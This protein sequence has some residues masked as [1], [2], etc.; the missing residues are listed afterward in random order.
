[1]FEDSARASGRPITPAEKRNVNTHTNTEKDMERPSAGASM[2]RKKKSAPTVGITKVAM[3][4]ESKNFAR[5]DH[6]AELS[7]IPCSRSRGLGQI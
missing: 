4:V 5:N 3:I 2:A 7:F 6:E 1:M